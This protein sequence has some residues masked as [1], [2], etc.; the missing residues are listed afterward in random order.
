M[1]PYYQDESATIYHGDCRDVLPVVGLVAH[2][3]T[4][5]PY[6]AETHAGARTAGKATTPSAATN[7]RELGPINKIAI[8]FDPLDMAS[9]LPTLL[10][11]ARHWT[12][13]FCSLEMLG[14]YRRIAGDAWMR[15][16]FWRRPDGAPQFTGDRPGQPGEGIAIMH[17]PL[18]AGREGRT[19]WN[20]GGAHAFYEYMTVKHGRVHP[21]QKPEPLMAALVS[22]FSNA[23]DLVL[24]PFMGSGTT[25]HAAKR[26]GRRS[27]GIEINEAFCEIA[28][29]RL[30][31]GSLFS[32]QTA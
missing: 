23:G 13:A 29:K 12:V 4:D 20:G 18:S 11:C 30:L 5:P 22:H 9:L 16:G 19:A 24:D 2:I 10:K 32:E 7:Q 21:T 8:E 15:A 31:Q 25:L 17:R 3:I 27:V 1:K 28:A 14:E 26:L 6:D